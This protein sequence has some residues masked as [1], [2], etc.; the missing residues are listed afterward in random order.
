MTHVNANRSKIKKYR[1]CAVQK[2]AQALQESFPEDRMG[3]SLFLKDPHRLLED[4][5]SA[6]W[7]VIAPLLRDGA[8]V[9]DILHDPEELPRGVTDRQSPGSYRLEPGASTRW[10][11]AVVGPQ[12]WKRWLH[13]PE[14]KLWSARRD[15]AGFEVTPEAEEWP[16]TIFFAVRPCDLAA[17]ARQQEVFRRAGDPAYAARRAATRIVAVNCGR[18]AETCF[19]AS[20]QTGPRAQAGYDLALT[21]IADGLLLEIGSEDGTALLD[22]R[23]LPAATDAQVREAARLIEAAAAS[24][25]RA[26]PPDIA[27]R[28][29]EVADSPRWEQVASRC[30]HCTN[31]TA[32]CPTCFC[33]DVTDRTSLDGAMAER[34]QRWDSCF[35]PDFSYLHGGPLR[36]RAAARYRQWMTH[37]LSN[38]HTQFGSS[39]C[40]GCGRCITWCPVG[41][42]LVAEARALAKGE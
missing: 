15:A 28:L 31:C 19:C 21:E 37:K 2:T 7:R 17:I 38:W 26:M 41:I 13:P 25:T 42:D 12:G 34:W 40:T 29:T 9:P 18:S 32:V 3:E 27:E 8:L 22:A 23:A 1:A 4:W 24:Q 6:G 35:S 5:L 39:G 30:L 14:R 11:E 36:R 33:T 10:F 20:M 16:A